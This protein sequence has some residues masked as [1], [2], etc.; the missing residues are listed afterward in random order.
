MPDRTGHVAFFDCEAASVDVDAVLETCTKRDF[1]RGTAEQSD[2]RED[3]G[4]LERRLTYEHWHP[5]LTVYSDDEFGPA[6]PDVDVALNQSLEVEAFEDSRAH[7][8]WMDAVF[9]LVCRLTALLKPTY[10]PLYFTSGQYEAVPDDRPIADNVQRPPPFGVYSPEVLADFGGVDSLFDGEPWYVAELQDGR[11]VVIES[12]SP[13]NESGWEPPEAADY[14]ERAEIRTNADE[15]GS[16]TRSDV[17]PQDGAAG[18]SDPFAALEPGEYG[19]DV[20]VHPDDIAPSFRNED[21]QFVRGYVDDQRNLRRADGGAFVRNVVSEAGSDEELVQKMLE[22]VPP[23]SGGDTHLVSALIHEAI[24]P[25][26]VRLEGPDDE[27]VVTKVMELDVETNK[28]DLLVSLGR[29]AQQRG[30]GAV[31]TIESALD[32]LADVEDA[33]AVEKVIEE[34]LL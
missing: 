20:G 22:D 28:Y 18:K 2:A 34:R 7:Q 6:Y 24:P 9:L 17:T 14:I 23:E 21:L 26:F 30:E 8:R 29:A 33:D 11:T 19:A 3:V 4:K 32:T 25:A 16:S 13:W 27:N 1:E 15:A 5:R 31:P 12:D 10:A